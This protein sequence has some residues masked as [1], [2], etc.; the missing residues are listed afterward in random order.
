MGQLSSLG[1]K[2]G[3]VHQITTCFK[4]SGVS[5]LHKGLSPSIH[6]SQISDDIYQ[7]CWGHG[8]AIFNAQLLNTPNISVASLGAK[9][10]ARTCSL[11][12]C[13]HVVLW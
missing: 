2:F 11:S 8:E 6:Q 13:S 5:V 1:T 12:S 9:Q 3:I 4:H 10:N 7:L